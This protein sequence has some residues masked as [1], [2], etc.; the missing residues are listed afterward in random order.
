MK[1]ITLAVL[2]LLL[3]VVAAALA[4]SVFRK[5]NVDRQMKVIIGMAIGI[6]VGIIIGTMKFISMGLAISIGLLLGEW[7]GLLW[8]K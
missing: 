5:K 1:D 8:K 6:S 3:I 2:P 4:V 7:A